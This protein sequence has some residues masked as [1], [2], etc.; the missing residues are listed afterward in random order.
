M[1]TNSNSVIYRTPIIDATTG[2]VTREWTRFFDQLQK[3]SFGSWTAW[4]PV[5]TPSAGTL[6][7]VSFDYA[8]YVTFGPMVFAAALMRFTPS[9]S[10]QVRFTLPVDLSHSMNGMTCNCADFVSGL[11]RFSQ[12]ETNTNGIIGSGTQPVPASAQ[13]FFVS[14]IYKID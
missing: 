9:A 3:N 5:L 2:L 1:P 7:G 13:V 14:L 8:T 4:T 12:I 11:P 6:S 10:C